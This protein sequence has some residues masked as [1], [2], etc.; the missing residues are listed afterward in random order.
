[1]CLGAEARVRADQTLARRQTEQ[2]IELEC[3]RSDGQWRP[4]RMG[5]QKVGRQWWIEIGNERIRFEHDGSGRVRM[6]TGAKAAWTSV[7]PSWAGHQVLCWG[8]ICARG[9]FPLD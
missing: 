1:M 6:K 8:S 7:E 3:S 9:A 5:I 2:A 4:C